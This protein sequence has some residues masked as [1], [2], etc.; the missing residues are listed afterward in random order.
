MNI[1]ALELSSRQGSLAVLS[2]D[3]LLAECELSEEVRRGSGLFRL[4]PD[5]CARAGVGLEALDLLVPGRGPGAYTGLRLA[6]TVAQVVALPGRRTVYP[7]S[8]G[9]ALAWEIAQERSARLVAVLDD[10]RRGKLWMGLFEQSPEGMQCRLPWTLATPDEV[11][12]LVPDGVVLV[13]PNWNNLSARPEFAPIQQANWIEEDRPPRARWV[14]AL[15]WSRFSANVPPEPPTPIYMHPA[16]SPP[17][18]ADGRR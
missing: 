16:V 7:V 3:I 12:R 5:L 15:A 10:A 1:L 4:L 2:K 8:S 9:E 13:S 14:G 6:L 11:A 18:P 17:A